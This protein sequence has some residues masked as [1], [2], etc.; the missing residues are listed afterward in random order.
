MTEN[1]KVVAIIPAA[2]LSERMGLG[3][4]KPLIEIKGKTVLERAVA[5]FLE[6]DE[7][8]QLVILCPPGFEAQFTERLNNPDPRIVIIGGG[9]TRQQSV[10]IGLQ[11]IKDLEDIQ[12]YYIVVH[13]AARCL[14]EKPLIRKVLAQAYTHKAAAL[15]IPVVDSLKLVNTER[16][17]IKE[18]VDRKNIFAVQ[19]PQVF[20]WDLLWSRHQ[21][22]ATQSNLDFSDDCGLVEGKHEVFIVEGS[23]SNLK[24]TTPIDLKFAEALLAQEV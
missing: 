2:G 18:N 7:I 8:K 14:I 22:Y 4:P 9:E 23:Q 11:K 5:P 16:T 20:S 10:F 24:I 19:T 3:K 13:D 15:A 1:R 21:F 12:E 17:K 6:L